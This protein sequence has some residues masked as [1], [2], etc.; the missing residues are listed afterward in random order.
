MR[1]VGI[2]SIQKA[3]GGLESQ[4][5]TGPVVLR[6]ALGKTVSPMEVNALLKSRGQPA[7]IPSVSGIYQIRC[8]RTGKIYVG[9]AVNLR[10]RWDFHRRALAI[11]QHHNP[12]L[13]AAWNL[14]G[15]E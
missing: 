14:Y 13:Q 3:H 12:H 4:L 15:E 6:K 8:V 10:A 11:N 1:A 5:D 7:Q 2:Q 9:S